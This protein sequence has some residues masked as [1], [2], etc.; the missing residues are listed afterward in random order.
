MVQIFGCKIEGKA[1]AA[2]EVPCP[3][4]TPLRQNLRQEP[5]PP[6]TAQFVPN[7]LKTDR[8]DHLFCAAQDTQLLSVDVDS[9]DFQFNE[10]RTSYALLDLF[11]QLNV[12]GSSVVHLAAK[13]PIE[14]LPST[15]C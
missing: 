8:F 4:S 5:E 9:L 15:M 1:Y 6:Y 14:T 3:L 7:H 2:S 12:E 13:R 11:K 10:P